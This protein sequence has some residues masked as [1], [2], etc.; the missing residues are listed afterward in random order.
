MDVAGSG[1]S[2]KAESPEGL[3][4]G[5]SAPIGHTDTPRVKWGRTL[6]NPEVPHASPD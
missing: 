2:E 5:A 4:S 1:K 6:S 3:V